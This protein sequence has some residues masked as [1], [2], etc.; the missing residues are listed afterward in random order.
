V[1]VGDRE[2]EEDI[3]KAERGQR[4]EEKEGR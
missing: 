1:R 3:T 4:E 2:R